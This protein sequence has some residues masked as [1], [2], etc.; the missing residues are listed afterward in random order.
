VSALLVVLLLMAAVPLSAPG[1]DQRLR[2]VTRARPPESRAAAGP[3]D[4]A[5][6]VDLVAAALGAGATPVA[7][8]DVVGRAVGGQEGEEVVRVAA[9]L[10]LGSDW[11][12]AW[13]GTHPHL[14][15][16]RRCLGLAFG[17]GAPGA[18]LLRHAA[19]ELRRRRHRAAQLEASRLGVRLVLPLGLCALPAFFALGV[20]P[21]VL[22]LAGQVLL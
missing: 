9:R 11:A 6:L 1:A 2:A 8:L 15:P 7:A 12:G 14:E 21:V 5:L 10:R 13:V 3:S 17:T 22:S 4:V 18:D 16:L 20:V 19:S